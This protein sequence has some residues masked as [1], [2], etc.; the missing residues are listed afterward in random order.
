[1]RKGF[2][3]VVGILFGFAAGV[4][5]DIERWSPLGPI[6]GGVVRAMVSNGL[7]VYAGTRGDGVF[8]REIA[9]ADWK[10]IG[11][12]N[13]TVNALA[14]H[15]QVPG[16]VFA[17]LQ[18]NG[19]QVS[20][21]GGLT[22]VET[23]RFTQDSILDIEWHPK[24]PDLI[25]LVGYLSGI[26]ISRDR[27][28]TWESRNSGLENAAVVRSVEFHPEDENIMF[29]ATSGGGV[30]KSQDGGASW[31]PANTGLTSKNVYCLAYQPLT[32][33]WYAGT[34]GH[35][36]FHSLDKGE[37]WKPMSS[38]IPNSYP[39]SYIQ[40]IEVDPQNSDLVYAGSREGF[41]ISRDRGNTWESEDA[42]L[43]FDVR[44]IEPLATGLLVGTWA[45][46]VFQKTV[47]DA[48]VLWNEGL[49]NVNISGFVINPADQSM[50]VAT[51]WGAGLYVTSDGGKSWHLSDS[52]ITNKM[53][54][55]T[56]ISPGNPTRIYTT[57]DGK[58]IFLSEDSG[59]TWRPINKGLNAGIVTSILLDPV[60][61]NRIY[62]G[63]E[64]RGV[65]RS[66]DAGETWQQTGLDRYAI[67][68]IAVNPQN[69]DII[70]VGTWGIT[71][72]AFE[73]L[74][75]LRTLD[76]GATWEIVL[77]LEDAALALAIDPR[78]P[79]CI[80][81]GT[82]GS[83]MFKSLDGGETWQ[84]INQGLHELKIWDLVIA[85]WDP[86]YLYVATGGGGIYYSANSGDHW[87]EMN[88]GLD[89]LNFSAIGLIS[90]QMNQLIAAGTS[91]FYSYTFSSPGSDTTSEPTEVVE[92]IVE[93]TEVFAN[94]PNP[95][96]SETWIPYQLMN[97]AD[98]KISIYGVDGHHLRTLRADAQSRGEYTTRDL[99]V[100]WDG[101][102]DRGE[103]VANGTYFYHFQAGDYSAAKKMVIMR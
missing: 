63:T 41:F 58:G 20:R 83:G 88:N 47:S 100:Y 5:A 67:W 18:S 93:R 99:A 53:T 65:Y 73:G 21:N 4:Y 42:L 59:R 39:Y 62:A 37:N 35:G 78:C 95:F 48:W 74:A 57:S 14:I 22:W 7:H 32:D 15:R 46:G 72:Y 29:A 87:V 82:H 77:E 31:A 12:R 49:T 89:N 84:Q 8:R 38:G 94:F 92:P 24:S 81:V 36:V 101:E 68:E 43:P 44:T 40:V 97:G 3:L 69:P 11:L 34:Y 23:N 9:C 51:T 17:G 60:H 56:V 90:G 19:L 30:F 79:D 25:C 70:Y 98:V 33:I 96:K 45:A 76:G 80:Y 13:L 91:G 55:D 66:D 54:I 71:A 1:M 26:A 16:T 61:P 103:P 28:L 85:P 27:G 50:M 86:N 6:Y 2:C 75:V 52:G 10:Q 102:N 64:Y